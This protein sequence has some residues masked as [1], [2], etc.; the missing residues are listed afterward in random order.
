MALARLTSAD[1]DRPGALPRSGLVAS[2]T[3]ATYPS[4]ISLRAHDGTGGTALLMPLFMAA[5][6][7]I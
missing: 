7:Q 6:T 2:L 5:R 1:L 3:I 4:Q